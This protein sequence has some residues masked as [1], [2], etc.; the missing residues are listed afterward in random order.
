MKSFARF[1]IF[2][3]FFVVTER[4]HQ[5][6]QDMLKLFF[7]SQTGAVKR[8]ERASKLETNFIINDIMLTI[9]RLNKAS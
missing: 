5:C 3:F 4:L 7:S 1:A 9:L 2:R 8:L 6:L